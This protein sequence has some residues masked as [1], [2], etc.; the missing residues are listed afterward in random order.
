[1]RKILDKLAIQGVPFLY[2]LYSSERGFGGFVND[3]CQPAVV[4]PD[5]NEAIRIALKKYSDLVGSHSRNNTL[6]V[7]DFATMEHDGVTVLGSLAKE[8]RD[9]NYPVRFVFIASEARAPVTLQRRVRQVR[10]VEGNNTIAEEYLWKAVRI[11]DPKRIQ[12]I[13]QFTGSIFKYLSVVK[14]VWPYDRTGTD[15]DVQGMI[16]ES[17]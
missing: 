13:V 5:K 7:I 6:I 1:M 8:I 10:L 3:I 15:A 9:Y 11:T 12:D 14:D 2:H 17:L 4:G 16:I